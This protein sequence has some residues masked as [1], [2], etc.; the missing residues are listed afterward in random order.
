MKGQVHNQGA[1]EELKV[2]IEKSVVEDVK[3]MAQK[4]GLQVDELVVIAL[5]K[6]RSRHTDL[7]GD[8]SRQE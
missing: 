4:S 2:K 5:K 8:K 7:L 3:K 1:L 6:Y